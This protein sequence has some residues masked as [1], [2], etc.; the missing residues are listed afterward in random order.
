M[1]VVAEAVGVS[2]SWFETTQGFEEATCTEYAPLVNSAQVRA[3]R[4]PSEYVWQGLTS[5]LRQFSGRSRRIEYGS[6]VLF[7]SIYAGFAAVVEIG[8]LSIS[9]AAGLVGLMVIGPVVIWMMVAWSAATVRRLHDLH[10]SAWYALV[11]FVP[12]VCLPFILILIFKDGPPTS[13]RF[14]TSPKYFAT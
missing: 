3:N 14:G 11:V 7:V 4:A 12:V 10:R 9:N 5:K 8:L 2:P 1:N 6:F 13:N